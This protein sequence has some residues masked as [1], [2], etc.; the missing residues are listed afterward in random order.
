MAEESPKT[1]VEHVTGW[2]VVGAVSILF[3]GVGFSTMTSP[4]IYIADA[5]FFAGFFLFIVKFWAW[6]EAKHDTTRKTALLLTGVTVFTILL[7]VGTCWLSSYIG[8][9]SRQQ[10]QKDISLSP[11]TSSPV[12]KLAEDHPDGG[13]LTEPKQSPIQ[14]SDVP[15]RPRSSCPPGTAVCL[16]H[17]Y[18]NRATG[19]VGIVDLEGEHG[20]EASGNVLP[21]PGVPITVNSAPN[22]IAIS[23]GTVVAPTVTNLYGRL[24]PRHIQETSKKTL[25]DCLSKNPGTVTMSYVSDSSDE[26]GLLQDWR[27]IFSSA[28]WQHDNKRDF[29]WTGPNPPKGIIISANV[30]ALPNGDVIRGDDDIVFDAVKCIENVP[31][32]RGGISPNTQIP[33]GHIHVFIGAS[34]Q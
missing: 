31:L 25:V 29:W 19:N 7:F 12:G 34:P 32:P 24:V 5:F 15:N 1:L 17:G 18:G 10:T 8:T 9:S 13:V 4:H 14:K 21:T 26:Q 20:S 22:G 27:E 11:P 33:R 30:Q 16:G 6:E 3:L 28:K 2:S 23:G